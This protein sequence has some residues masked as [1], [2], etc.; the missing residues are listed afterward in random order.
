MNYAISAVIA[1]NKNSFKMKFD[2]VFMARDNDSKITL[3]NKG[4]FIAVILSDKMRSNSIEK[5]EFHHIVFGAYLIVDRGVFLRS[6]KLRQIPP[7]W[8]MALIGNQFKS[9]RFTLLIAHQI[10]ISQIAWNFNVN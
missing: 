6:S 7:N 3:Q 5:Q 8:W 2:Y 9:F 4:K 10:S 1:E